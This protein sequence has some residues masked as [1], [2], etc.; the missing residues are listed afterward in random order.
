MSSYVHTMSDNGGVHINSG[1]TN[2]AFH[3]AALSLCGHSWDKAG[4]IWYE[5]LR[6]PALKPSAGFRSFARLTLQIA[7]AI[8]APAAPRRRP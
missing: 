2:R 8:T 1:I 6:D 5:T 4:P 3:L 7:G